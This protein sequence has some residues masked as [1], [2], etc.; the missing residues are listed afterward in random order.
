[1][2]FRKDKQWAHEDAS[3]MMFDD[4]RRQYKDTLDISD[5]DAEYIKALIRGE[6]T[7]YKYVSALPICS[8]AELSESSIDCR[9]SKGKEY[10]F[11]I[12]ANKRNG[13]DVDKCVLEPL[14]QKLSAVLKLAVLTVTLRAT[15]QIRLH[16]ARYK[17]YRRTW[18]SYYG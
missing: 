14:L 4:M 12:V 6:P 9:N 1:M 5:D 7:R 2:T 13:I 3:E 16:Y 18:Q 11:E 10:L 17:S 15:S 8:D